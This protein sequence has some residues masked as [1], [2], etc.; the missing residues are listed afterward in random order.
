MKKFFF[1]LLMTPFTL[2]AYEI[3]QTPI[4]FDAQ[5]VA[6]TKKYIKVHYNLDVSDIKIVPKI[7]FIHYT[8][9]NSYEKTLKRFMSSKL[10]SDRPLI[11]KG[12]I[13]NVSTHFLIEQNG[14]IH[15][16]MPLDFMARHVIGLNYNSIGIENVGGE[17]RQNNLTPEQLKAN[18]F[19]VNYLKKKFNTIEYVAG[20][21]EYECFDKTNLWLEVDKTYRTEKSDPGVRF[22]KE[23]RANIKGFKEAPCD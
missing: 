10:P 8:A 4:S 18:I 9:L 1:I 21:Y 5:R 22:M 19:L 15:Q 13:L 7:I 23:L 2:F 20:H 3:I 11:K 16:L 17:N 6:L 12:G 14:T